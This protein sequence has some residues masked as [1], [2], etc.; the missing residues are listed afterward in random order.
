MFQ[1]KH[2]FAFVVSFR[3]LT[4]KVAD[5][6]QCCCHVINL[7]PDRYRDCDICA[8]CVQELIIKIKQ[9]TV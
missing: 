8:I 3:W 7:C 2:P 5:A 6:P 4:D 9:I 1:L